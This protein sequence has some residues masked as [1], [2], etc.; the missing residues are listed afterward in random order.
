MDLAPEVIALIRH[1]A[2]TFPWGPAR[3]RY[4]ADTVVR[5]LA[6]TTSLIRS[7]IGSSP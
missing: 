3:R 4:L 2:D 5:R 7:R 6:R 1:T